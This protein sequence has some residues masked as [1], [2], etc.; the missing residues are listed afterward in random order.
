MHKAI[1]EVMQKIIDNGF[2]VYLVG[3]YVRDYCLD[4]TSTDYDLATNAKPSDLMKIFNNLKLSEYGSVVLK[5]NSFNFEI[6]TFRIE[7]SYQKNRF[8]K[9]KYANSINQDILRRDFTMNA[10]Y[11]DINENIIDILDGRKDIDNKLIKMVG[12]PYKKIEEDA[13]RILRAIRFATYYN[14]KLEKNLINA[15][16]D[17]NYLVDNLSSFRIKSELDKIFASNNLDYGLKLI[18]ELGLSKYLYLDNI[19]NIKYSNNF[20]GIWAQFNNLDKYNFSKCEKQQII[21]IKECLEKDIF[22]PMI[23]YKYG[24]YIITIVA[25]IRGVDSKLIANYFN[26]LS[27]KDRKDIK[28]NSNEIIALLNILPGKKIKD[29]YEDLENKILKNEL[30]NDNE[31]IK[32]YI[33][34]EYN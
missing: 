32:K 1:K 14:F 4:I 33:L 34:N 2:E 8:P 7:Y 28:I 25:S 5:Y 27:I 10:L 12:D 23:M 29:I 24:L 17:L 6:T 30:K 3:G 15:I 18:N 21:Y 22:N 9:F 19:E 13:L 11:M 26:K 16:K 31:I 20:L